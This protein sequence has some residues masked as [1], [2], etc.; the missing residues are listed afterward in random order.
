M[1]YCITQTVTYLIKML[2]N[3]S[4]HLS[5]YLSTP[6]WIYFSGELW[7]I[8]SISNF[9]VS[10]L[11][12]KFGWVRTCR[13][14]S[15]W[16]LRAPGMESG[17]VHS[18]QLYHLLL[19]E[20]HTLFLGFILHTTWTGRSKNNNPSP[21]FISTIFSKCQEGCNLVCHD[22]CLLPST[23]HNVCNISGVQYKVVGWDGMDG[24][25]GGWVDG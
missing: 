4:I 24:W 14:S 18:L 12:K 15:H 17:H 11:Q 23:W 20:G 8:R 22:H 25:M 13:V 5:I 21:L 19:L 3:K 9:F 16:L 6:Y 10:W 7:L 2:V 1:Q